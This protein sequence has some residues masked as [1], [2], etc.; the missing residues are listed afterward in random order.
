MIVLCKMIEVLK[1]IEHTYNR[2]SL[3]IVGVVPHL[4]QYISYSIISTL[5]KGKKTLMSDKS[6]K[7]TKMDALQALLIAENSISGAITSDRILVTR[8]ALQF[9]QSR[10]LKQDEITALLSSIK[11]LVMI[12]DIR[13][14]I[15]KSCDTAFLYWHK[16]ILSP[17]FEHVFEVKTNPH[18]LHY[19]FYAI[20][21]IFG[22][23]MDLKHLDN[24]HDLMNQFEDEIWSYVK[25]K[26]LSPLCHE[27]ET[28]LRLHVHSHLKLDDRNPFKTGLK[29]V[30]QFL[31][32]QP[33]PFGD[34]Y[35]NIK[36]H[37]EA[38]LERIFYNL[39][40][41]ALHNWRTYGE[42]RGLALQKFGTETVDDHLPAQT[43][44]QGLD[45]IEIMRNINVFVSRF[46]YNLNNQVL[47]PVQ[48]KKIS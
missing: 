38:Y 41:V 45:V 16:V 43:L 19:T 26:I 13:M 25:D 44:E 46:Q 39:T 8:L 37:V 48:Y 36:A 32:V 33:I 6:N 27:L 20:Q 47:I 22:D 34:K 1:A 11:R 17:Y 35:I 24:S 12:S 5:R 42:M 30:L 9:C 3:A 14:K 23:I 40:T 29:H 15:E 10:I 31:H 4:C 7:Q 18:R 21:D 2:H 28:D